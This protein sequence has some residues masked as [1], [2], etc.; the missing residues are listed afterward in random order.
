MKYR[1]YHLNAFRNEILPRSQTSYCSIKA[2]QK[3]LGMKRVNSDMLVL[4][5]KEI[6]HIVRIK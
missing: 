5:A 3:S 4:F 6:Y 1:I 2:A